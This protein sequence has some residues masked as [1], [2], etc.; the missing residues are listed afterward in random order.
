[1]RLIHENAPPS[2][3]RVL[4][5]VV[6]GTWF[7]RV[8]FKPLQQ[9]SVVSSSLEERVSVMRL[10]P[11]ALVPLVHSTAFLYG[12]KAA[13]L[14]S[15]ALV[16]AGVALRPM[17]VVSCILMTI[18]A[19]H[20]RGFAGHIDHE[21]ILILLAGIL[22]TLL[23]LADKRLESKGKPW[24]TGPG[25]PTHAGVQMTSVL[26]LLCLVYTMVG[27]YRVVHGSPEIWTTHSLTFWAL[28]NAYETVEPMAGWGKFVITY[29]WL[30]RMLEAG[31]PVIT[32]FELTAFIALF[33]KW[34][35]WA[36]LLMMVPFHL[37]SLFVLDVFF[38]ENMM[39][40]LLFF[41]FWY[42]PIEGRDSP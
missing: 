31:F 2:A 35:R 23:A 12:L 4:R 14:L 32:V 29:P 11:H 38:W 16:I 27:V 34:Y 9:L 8:A 17:M 22:M 30:A 39:L 33:S 28:R 13:T 25:V 18:F 42:R 37:L 19:A 5:I 10:V 6:F 3:L 20:W 1:M 24:P 26:A 7:A 41:T 36:F 40:Y 15:F 21:S